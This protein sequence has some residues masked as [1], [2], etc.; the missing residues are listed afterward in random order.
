MTGTR[1]VYQVTGYDAIVGGDIVFE[2]TVRPEDGGHDLGPEGLAHQVQHVHGVRRV[3]V[4]DA[5]TGERLAENTQ[6]IGDEAGSD[7]A[8]E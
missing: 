1:Q 7:A 3:V 8:V 6:A 2:A 4:L 5:Y